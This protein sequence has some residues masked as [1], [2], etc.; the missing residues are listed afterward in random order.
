MVD[1]KQLKMG[2]FT[3]SFEDLRVPGFT[4]PISILRKYDTKRPQSGDFGLG[5]TLGYSDVNVRLDVNKNA[6]VTLPDGRRV[7][8]KYTPQ[9]AAPSLIGC[10]LIYNTLY[11]PAPGVYDKL[12]N[13]DCPQTISFG[14][15]ALCGFDAFRAEVW[16]LT[17]KEGLK[18]TIARGVVT[19]MEDRVG[20]WMDISPNGVRTNFGRDV[21]FER[22]SAGRITRVNEPGGTAS[23][24]YEY[25]TRGRLVRSTD[26]GG[27]ATSFFYE[28]SSLP[29]YLTRIVDPLGRAVL[30]MVFDSQGRLIAQCNA[31]GD[32][33]T[34]SGCMQMSSEPGARTFTAINGRGFKTEIV[35][36]DRGNVIAEKRYT[37]ATTHLDTLRTYDASNNLLTERDPGGGSYSFAYD[38]KG[39]IVSE[40]DPGGRTHR[41]SYDAIC[42]KP[43]SETD[44]AGATTRFTYDE[45]CNIRFLQDARG[46]TSEYRYN[47]H[48]QLERYID[49]NGSSWAWTYSEDGHLETATDPFGKVSRY[50][51]NATGQLLSRTDRL[52][53]QMAYEYDTSQR[54]TAELWGNGRAVRYTYDASGLLLTAT[55][56]E[57][58]MAL[59]YD[60][61]GRLRSVDSSATTPG[62]PRVV[63]TYRYDQ[64]GNVTHAVD[65][66]GGTTEF[67]YDALD[68]LASFTQSGTGVQ[69]KRVDVEYDA[70]SLTRTMRRFASLSGTLAVA[71][72]TYGVF[73]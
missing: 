25:D 17:T 20:N 11:T 1:T 24:R 6:F 42:N 58:A 22:D 40:T 36:D 12:E 47:S 49:P 8:F 9:C 38:G 72:T 19:R 59:T 18:Y 68:R 34:L 51:F 66:F 54:R 71:N 63:M 70:S 50:R 16:K 61:N 73:T 15:S 53:R 60:S 27:Q 26:V 13:L 30:R 10:F 4:F 32:I 28:H 65:S 44:P 45:D 39:N 64:N 29:H 48:G 23:L 33:A 31:D 55:D 3:L 35:S 56:T 52:G 21:T 41:Y 7:N 57:S 62:A 67:T 69:P 2:D 37:D 5:W 46:K 43:I 14:A